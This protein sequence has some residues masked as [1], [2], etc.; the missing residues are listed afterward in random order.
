[1]SSQP[2]TGKIAYFPSDVTAGT[3][4]IIAAKTATPKQYYFTKSND[5]RLSVFNGRVKL[6]YCYGLN[7]TSVV[8]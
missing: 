1:M 5:Y 2:I 8:C 7:G 3:R 6:G 4:E